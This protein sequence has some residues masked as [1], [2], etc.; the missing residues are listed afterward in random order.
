M[1][2]GPSA[3]G[4]FEHEGEIY[5]ATDTPIL[6]T[7][8]HKG[9]IY[10]INKNAPFEV[11]LYDTLAFPVNGA[12]QLAYRI[13]AHLNP[14]LFGNANILF[15]ATMGIADKGYG[16]YYNW[17]TA[18]DA[19]KI[20][21][22]GWHVQDYNEYSYISQYLGGSSVSGGKMKEVGLSHWTTPNTGATDESGFGARG[23]GAR[24]SLGPFTNRGLAA[25]F[26]TT[27]ETGGA[28]AYYINLQNASAAW[29][30]PQNSKNYGFS[31]RLAKDS[32]TLQEGQQGTYIGNNGIVYKTICINGV[33]TLAENLIETKYRDGSAIPN[34]IPSDE[35]AALTTGAYCEWN[36]GRLTAPDC[37]IT[38][39]QTAKTFKS[40]V[41][42]SA[43]I[44]ITE[45]ANLL[46]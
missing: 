4:L 1:G 46:G 26:W 18:T 33:E 23:A 14:S 2:G 34:V 44:T 10:K 21:N 43:T 39:S 35:W 12:S 30:G 5:I 15:G 38:F 32:T 36:S 41:A 31:L 37:S 11:T 28:T 25:N 17:W 22:T 8:Y 42:G 29:Q 9:E 19:R 20:A 16:L 6:I 7:P 24:S 45:N 40:P 3:Y 27:N 13:T